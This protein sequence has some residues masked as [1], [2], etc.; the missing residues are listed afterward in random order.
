MN[1]FTQLFLANLREFARDRMA[2]FWTLAFPVVF[3]LIFGLIFGR[4]DTFSADLGLV[5]EDNGA[6]A[7]ELAQ[8]LKRVDVLKISEGARQAELD[9]LRGGDRDA[10]V[11]IPAGASDAI[12]RAEAAPVELHYDPARSSSQ[13]VVSIVE[14]SLQSAAQRI[15][16]QPEIFKLNPVTVQ[17]KQLRAIDYLIPG[18][19]AMSILNLALFATAQPIISLRSQGVLRRLGATPLGRPTLLAAYIAMRVLIAL[20]Q[21]AIIVAVGVALFGLTM[22]GS[23]L[24]FGGVL[25]LGTLSFIAIAFLI[26]A[27]A[28]TEE[29]GSALTSALQLPMMFLSGIFFPIEALPGFMRPVTN[30]LP[31]TYLAD[32][33]RQV[34]VSATPYHSM[35][36]NGMVLLG[37]LVVS[38]A[39][40]I[41][42][43][44]WE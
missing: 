3:I 28:K 9:A 38:G 25:L 26:A 37:W 14:Q 42:Y 13:I 44:R 8:T 7:Q 27:I 40:A 34:M 21:T 39:L 11:V 17:A 6:A 1:A 33:L 36:V 20:T 30:A 32:A 23:W 16:P 24:L 2:L 5:I 4:P 43:F 18:I 29:S 15:R 10:V 19:L 12:A 31:L 41:R 22:S 35:A